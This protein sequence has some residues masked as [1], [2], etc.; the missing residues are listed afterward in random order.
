LMSMRTLEPVL[1]ICTEI[2]LCYGSHAT[3]IGLQTHLARDV[4]PNVRAI[5][6]ARKRG[7]DAKDV[8]LVEGVRN[9]KPGK[10]QDL[11]ILTSTTS[12]PSVRVCL[13]H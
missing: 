8:I 5:S 13:L 4:N 6:E 9:G 2:A 10:G 1:I 3:K 7:S 12:F 11:S